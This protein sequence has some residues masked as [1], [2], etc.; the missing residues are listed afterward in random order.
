MTLKKQ[1][2]QLLVIAH[3]SQ[4]LDYVTGF[5]GLI[6]PLILWA[7]NKDR[8]LEMDEH[9]KAILNFQ[10]SMLIYCII[11]VPMILLFGFGILMMIAIGIMAFVFPIVNAV[12]A[13]NGEEPY[14]PLSLKII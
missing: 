4:L 1:D 6:V 12:K 9:G 8:V 3:L 13:S 5:G 2:N 11:A 14:Y 7:S 10:I